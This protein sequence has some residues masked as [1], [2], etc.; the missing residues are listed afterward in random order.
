MATSRIHPDRVRVLREGD[1]VEGRYV[2]YWM[3]QSQRAEHNDALELAIQRAN[4]LGLPLVVG[5][6]LMDDYPAANLRHYRFLV[7]GLQETAGALERRGVRFVLRKGHPVDVALELAGDATEVV[8]D[9]GYLRHQKAW[10]KRLAEEAGRPVTEVEADVVVPVEAASTKREWAARTLRPKLRSVVNEYLVELRT[11]ALDRSLDDPPEGESLEDLDALLDSMSLDR[12]IDPVSA[13]FQ[14][15]TAQARFRLRRFVE[16]ALPAYDDRSSLPEDDYTSGLSPY[17][18]FGQISPVYVALRVREAETDRDERKAFL[19]QMVVRRELAMN[20]VQFTDDYDEY[21]CLPDWARQT[22]DEHRDDERPNA[23]SRDELEAA[24][25]HD[26]YWNAAMRDMKAT[27]FL[28]NTMRM[29]WGKKIL[30]W[31]A[32]PEEAYRATIEL[33]DRYFLDGRDPSSYTNVGW[34]FGLH[35][36][37]WQE[38]EIFGKVRY[39]SSGGLERKYDMGAY[40]ERVRERAG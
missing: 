3:Q 22:L 8:C 18:H 12:S 27:G 23:Y 9:R 10:R 28:H 2:L 40:L 26:E 31:S 32:S 4:E 6:G 13:H 16:E 15:G 34:I 25:T 21:S 36:R 29:Y 20:F 39:M 24:E 5:F 37:P 33:N 17:L 7:E 35:D 11:T 19:E 30:E 1:P 38:R 14:G